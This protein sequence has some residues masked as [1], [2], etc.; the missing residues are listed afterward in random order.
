MVVA[1]NGS[2]P[3][4]TGSSRG[5][6][7]CTGRQMHLPK[8]LDPGILCGGCCGGVARLEV[9]CGG[10]TRTGDPQK[11]YGDF[12]KGGDHRR[13]LP[14]HDPFG[15]VGGARQDDESLTE[16]VAGSGA[17]R[18]GNPRG[19]Q[20]EPFEEHGPRGWSARKRQWSVEALKFLA[21]GLHS[22]AGRGSGRMLQTIAAVLASKLDC[23]PQPPSPIL[24]NPEVPP[25]PIKC[26]NPEERRPCGSNQV[27]PY[28]YRRFQTWGRHTANSGDR[29]REIDREPATDRHGNKPT[30]KRQHLDKCRD[31]SRRKE[32]T[33]HMQTAL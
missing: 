16:V 31:Q 18:P 6:C 3:F 12:P 26:C 1:N 13:L 10:P 32:T 21:A 22:R 33:A 23:R 20:E 11:C 24:C 8:K 28:G 19:G 29:D 2:A 25:L 27:H 4:A 17:D 15:G 14:D 9:L 30:H 7:C 5:G